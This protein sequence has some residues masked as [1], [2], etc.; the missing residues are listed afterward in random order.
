MRIFHHGGK[1][2]HMATL[3]DAEAIEATVTASEGPAWLSMIAWMAAPPDER[4]PEMVGGDTLAGMTRARQDELLGAA[5]R[6]VAYA[7]RPADDV[8]PIPLDPGR[9]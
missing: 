5:M 7:D 1:T 8:C 6:I 3:A 9:N 4:P 2:Y